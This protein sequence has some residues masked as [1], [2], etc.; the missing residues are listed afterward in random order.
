MDKYKVE[1]I[2]AFPYFTAK[3]FRGEFRNVGQTDFF[4]LLLITSG[5]GKGRH[6]D[7]IFS[8]AAGDCFLCGEKTTLE[9]QNERNNPLIQLIVNF[10]DNGNS[11]TNYYHKKFKD[12]FYFQE[13]VN[14][15][16]FAHQQEDHVY[17]N[18]LLNIALVELLNEV[19]YE[20]EIFNGPNFEYRIEIS[21]ICAKIERKPEKKWEVEKLANSMFLSKQQFYRLFKEFRKCSPQQFITKCKME[22]AKR[23]LTYSSCGVAE[24]G[25][26][27]GYSYRSQFCRDFKKI[28]GISPKEFRNKYSKKK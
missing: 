22:K 19:N 9:F 8:I 18:H 26:L 15:I 28:Y 21:A 6:N 12:P 20:G 13:T 4:R 1:L 24:A 14:R 16:M 5:K 10:N 7:K 11:L 23:I 25:D 2:R 27:L 3:E 17:G